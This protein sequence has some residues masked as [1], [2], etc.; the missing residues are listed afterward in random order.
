MLQEKIII[1]NIKIASCH[2]L[3]VGLSMLLIGYKTQIEEVT[4]M[5]LMQLQLANLILRH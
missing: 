4:I 1:I 2:P 5:T 3:S